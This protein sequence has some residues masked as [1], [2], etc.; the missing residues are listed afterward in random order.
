VDHVGL[1]R[2]STQPA[3]KP[4]A[5]A[6]GLE[7]NDNAVDRTSSPNGLPAPAMQKLQ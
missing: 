7:S 1:D 4:E 2:M 6:P 3:R 5:I